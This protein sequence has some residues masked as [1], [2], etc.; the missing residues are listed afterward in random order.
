MNKPSRSRPIRTSLPARRL[1]RV[2]ARDREGRE[3]GKD[4]GKGKEKGKSKGKGKGGKAKKTPPAGCPEGACY[5]YWNTRSC[6]KGKDCQYQHVGNPDVPKPTAP[7]PKPKAKKQPKP[8]APSPKKA[9]C[10]F[11]AQ[12]KCTAGKDCQWSHAPAA[13]QGGGEEAAAPAPKPKA[14][15][16]AKAKKKAAAVATDAEP[17]IV[18]VPAACSVP[19]SVQPAC[20]A[21]TGSL[22]PGSW[23]VD[24]G[25][26]NHLISADKLRISWKRFCRKTDVDHFF[27]NS[28]W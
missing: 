11:H 9:P 13:K 25:S 10:K 18:C 28:K 4:K 21:M 19:I 15:S 7:A 24:T 20:S 12:G 8:T 23:I 1:E 14:K 6:P 5:T 3:K 2:R 27:S 22:P 16:K 26:G 17:A